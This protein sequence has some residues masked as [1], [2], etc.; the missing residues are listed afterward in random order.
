[1]TRL[2]LDASCIIYLVEAS[3]PFHDVSVQRILQY[4]SAAMITSTLSCLECRVK[5]LRVG[6]APLVARYDAFFDKA[7]PAQDHERV[8]TAR[9]DG[10]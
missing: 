5:P 9:C 3:S 8:G 6:D 2:Y 7:I 10:S 4:N 1:M